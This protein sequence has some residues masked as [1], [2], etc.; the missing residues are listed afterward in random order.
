MQASSNSEVA[1]TG[2]QYL[3]RQ[4]N[5][6]SSL[7]PLFVGFMI[8]TLTAAW[9]YLH[10]KVPIYQSTATILIKEDKNSNDSWSMSGLGFNTSNKIIDNEIV[11][12]TSR[13]VMKEV[14]KKLALYAPVYQEENLKAV[15]AY[16]LS[17]IK[18]EVRNPDSLQPCE[19]V[20]FEYDSSKRHVIVDMQW[21]PLNNWITT[22]WGVLR[23][24]PS[25]RYRPSLKKQQLFFSLVNIRDVAG[26]LLDNMTIASAGKNSTVIYLKLTDAVPE[27]AE[28]VLNEVIHVYTSADMKD[29]NTLAANALSISE[30]R[31][32]YVTSDLDSVEAALQQFRAREG[33]IDISQQGRLYLQSVEFNDQQ[34]SNINNELAVLS[35]V[36]KYVAS[37]NE[38]PQNNTGEAAP[39]LAP[40]LIGIHD[41]NLVG[42]LKSLYD[43]ELQYER[44]KKIT[45]ENSPL[46]VSL[47]NQISR[48][49]P[50]ILENIH[51]QRSNL[52]VSRQNVE[53]TTGAYTSMLSAMP[54][55][56]RKLLDITRQQAIKN[57][58]Y[59]FLLQKREEA[60]LAL[61]ASV[62]DNRLIDSAETDV[63]PVSP[64]RSLVYGV[65]LLLGFCIPFGLIYASASLNQAVHTKE[66]IEA[67]SSFPV[68]G[69]I[70]YHKS[71][72]PLVISEGER[73]Y[74][75]EQFRQVRTA[76]SF[77]G[78]HDA[79]NKL[80]VTSSVPGE[81]KTFIAAN[82][83][84]S[85]A[86]TDKKVVLVEL[87]LRKPQLSQMFN[88][89][90]GPGV[91]E[92]L[93][94]KAGI[95]QIICNTNAHSN[96][97][98]IPAGAVPANPSELILN[99]RLDKL[100]SYLENTFDYIILE[101]APV[102]VVTD[103]YV[104]AG[105][106]NAT[107]YIVRY[108]YTKKHDITLAEETLTMKGLQN[109]SV[110]FNAVKTRQVSKS[111]YYY[112]EAKQYGM[113]IKKQPGHTI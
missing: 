79:R 108:G 16:A 80:L 1:K 75:A 53:T 5:K 97:S 32:R 95:A 21:Y 38:L 66:E 70:A 89:A 54:E 107:L 45:A 73:S 3:I 42:L 31:L 56:E 105:Y 12:L 40:S 36:E 78:I 27:R 100:I 103:A 46:M 74:V 49:R 43:A 26:S 77:A 81:G 10:Y 33:V 13:T 104:I 58:I 8:V 52:E 91:S 99:K 113:G 34:V 29:K 19:K 69:E 11:V 51:N 72:N 110:I 62:S 101:T 63:W 17:P 93:S 4:L 14:V 48:L 71:K 60:A 22:K 87:D 2:G 94:G 76:L 85:L 61:A 39:A 67:L 96:L 7:W 15:P 55:K 112:Y 65:A 6:Y 102:N 68:M 47:H 25:G 30:E 92:Y 35:Q 57:K 59:T 23:F 28:D 18:V 88:T 90:S 86:L 20:Y 111:A 84:I 98:I 83:A 64:K 50:G 44:L 109:A 37:K 9:V 82:L 106:C 41:E 24:T